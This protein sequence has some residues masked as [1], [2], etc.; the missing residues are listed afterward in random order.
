MDHKRTVPRSS[1]ILVIAAFLCFIICLGSYAPAA[2]APA[3]SKGTAA[4]FTP[5]GRTGSVTLDRWVWRNPLPQGNVINSITYGKGMFVA[6]GYDTSAAVGSIFTSPDGVTWTARD[7]GTPVVLTSVAYGNNA[8][9]AVGQYDADNLGGGNGVIVS[10]SDG[11][12]WNVTYSSFSTAQYGG[13]YG[14]AYGNGTFAAVGHDLAPGGAFFAITSPDGVTW[15]VNSSYAWIEVLH[16]F[17]YGKGMFVA[18]G[19]KGSVYTSTDGITWT[20]RFTGYASDTLYGVA[21]NGTNRFV[22]VGHSY[23]SGSAIIVTSSDG[24]N[25]V[26]STYWDGAS[27]GVPVFYGVAYG[28]GTFVA[29]GW[30]RD[31]SPWTM[32][33]TSPDGLTWTKQ[34]PMVSGPALLSVIYANNKFLAAGESAGLTSPDGKTWTPR[35]SVSTADLNAVVYGNNTFVAAGSVPSVPNSTTSTA[36]I[37]KSA[38]GTTWTVPYSYSIPRNEYGG[39]V[40]GVAYGNGT[41]VAVGLNLSQGFGS[42][43]SSTDGTTW[44]PRDAGL[45][46]SLRGVTYGMNKFVAVGD[47]GVILTSS[48]GVTWTSQ[49]S[50]VSLA[51]YGVAYGNNTFVAIGEMGAVMVSPNGSLWSFQHSDIIGYASLRGIT[52]GGNIFT[53][54]G[55]HNSVYQKVYTSANGTGWTDQLPATDGHL[56]G[57]TYGNSRFVAAG[58]AYDLVTTSYN[59]AVLNSFNGTLWT[60]W[61][62]RNSPTVPALRAAAYGNSSFVAV[63]D[64]GTILQ[65][66]SNT[67]AASVSRSGAGAVLSDP[68]GVTCGKICVAS[69]EAGSTVTFTAVPDAHARFGAWSGCDSVSGSTCTVTMNKNVSVSVTF[70]PVVALSVQF[71]GTG[72][73][74]VTI[75]PGGH[76]CQGTC[77]YQYDPNQQVTITPSPAGRSSFAYWTGACSGVSSTCSF[78]LAADSTVNVVFDANTTKKL[79]LLVAPVKQSA[80]NGA[81][82]SSDGKICCGPLSVCK[83]QVCAATYYPGA[84]VTLYA[85]PGLNTFFKGFTPATACT[86]TT[87]NSCVLTVNATKTV[88]ATFAGPQLLVVGRLLPDGGKGTVTSAPP[89]INCSATSTACRHT[90]LYNNWVTLTA[91]AG[92]DSVFTG[93]SPAKVCTGE[94]PCSVFMNGPKAVYATFKGPQALTVVRT[95]VKGGTGTVVTTPAGINC[96]V[97]G[98][99]CNHKFTYKSQVTVTP[100]PAPGSSFMGW[101]PIQGCTGLGACT[102]TMDKAKN[103]TVRFKKGVAAE[104]V[105]DVEEVLDEKG[106]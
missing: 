88:Y 43:L 31:V 64:G 106:E 56:Y 81:I 3:P 84:P 25:W 73:G 87:T 45:A 36:T 53:A 91:E 75:N 46:A 35:Y 74:S 104:E 60:Q 2:A 48:N 90:Y 58:D 52:F 76:T 95:S 7:P 38:D 22:A 105:G 99:A 89:G 79:T 8:F 10:S 14:V 72:R 50:G 66:G 97:K 29:V 21:F 78:F 33:L 77:S 5:A 12:T 37:M 18:V 100:V 94:G 49:A 85:D 102:L 47:N 16:G 6:V 34:D 86:V 51:L 19:E 44:Y 1:S 9:V 68:A 20:Q 71:G 27:G 23:S 17:T 54:V 103:L 101:Y 30:D 40:Y 32:A 61:V 59:G 96:G 65:S 15:T 67:Y 42:I 26:E 55:Y 92:P 80:G 63:G 28:N 57:V 13:F 98:G 62:S 93:W 11:I 4:V 83:K 24:L 70:L 41:Y 82:T 69:F 39:K